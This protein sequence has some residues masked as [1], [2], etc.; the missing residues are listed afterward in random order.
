MAWDFETARVSTVA[1]PGATPAIDTDNFDIFVFT[2]LATAI[3]SLT[4]NLT[5]TPHLGDRVQFRFVDN[6]TARAITHGASFLASGVSALLTTTAI[7]KRHVEEFQ[8]DGTVW[9]SSKVDATG[10]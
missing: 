3:T 5:G 6:G 4:T 10:Y 1:A 8:W 9:V 2:G 7:S